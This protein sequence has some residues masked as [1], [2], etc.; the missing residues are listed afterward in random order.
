MPTKQNTGRLTFFR[1]V[2]GHTVMRRGGHFAPLVGDISKFF[3]VALGRNTGET[4]TFRTESNPNKGNLWWGL[5]FFLGGRSSGQKI[6]LI[7]RQ[8]NGKYRR[9][10][11]EV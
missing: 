3:F 2:V 8:K 1:I 9:W 5:C 10:G 11:E 7:I 4:A 6:K